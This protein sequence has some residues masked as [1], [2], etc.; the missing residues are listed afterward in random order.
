MDTRARGSRPG[1]DVLFST[2]EGRRK[3]ADMLRDPRV[4]LL[5]HSRY[6]L[7]WHARLGTLR[8]PGQATA[9]A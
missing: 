1:D 6:R 7:S 3:T 8:L 4:T 9:V 5:P 2:I